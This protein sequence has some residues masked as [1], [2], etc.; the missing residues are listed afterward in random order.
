M[1]SREAK[2]IRSALIS[3]RGKLTNEELVYINA[4]IARQ[5]LDLEIEIKQR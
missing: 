4:E 3:H 1:I 2:E 5:L